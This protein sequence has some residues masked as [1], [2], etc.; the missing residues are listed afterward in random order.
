[1]ETPLIP[2]S[3]LP[4]AVMLW[5]VPLSLPAQTA[6]AVTYAPPEQLR[7]YALSVCL[8]NAFPH[9]PSGADASAA[10]AG[11]LELGSAPLE[12]YPAIVHLAQAFLART[13]TGQS[14]SPLQTMKCID[15][16]HSP[17]LRLMVHR[18]AAKPGT[19]TR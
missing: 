9:S 3:V 17:G 14:G 8:A 5:L 18:Y 2:R 10:A 12:A 15:F 13:Y 4:A 16:Y 11:Y 1:M 6:K 19:A 7:N